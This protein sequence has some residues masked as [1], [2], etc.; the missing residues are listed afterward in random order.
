MENKYVE[1]SK[2]QCEMQDKNRKRKLP[3]TDEKKRNS[4]YTVKD[5]KREWA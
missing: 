1:Y 4:R 2:E 3:M 5:D